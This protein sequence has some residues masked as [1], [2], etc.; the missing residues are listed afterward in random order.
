MFVQNVDEAVARNEDD[1]QEDQSAVSPL[2]VAVLHDAEHAFL[3]DIVM[4]VEEDALDLEGALEEAAVVVAYLVLAL[5]AP[6]ASCLGNVQHASEGLLHAAEIFLHSLVVL[7]V[8]EVVLY[9]ENL[10]QEVAVVL[11]V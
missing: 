4:N 2:A 7:L 11:A 1:G 8:L 10:V 5:E 3:P 6:E 9:R